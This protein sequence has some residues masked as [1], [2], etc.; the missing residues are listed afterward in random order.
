MM[1]AGRSSTKRPRKSAES[2]LQKS[3]GDAE[4]VA[5]TAATDSQAN[6]PFLAKLEKIG[7]NRK[8]P[9]Q[10]WPAK[11]VRTAKYQQEK[12]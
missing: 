8:N 10:K 5:P 7:K 2:L 6:M 9:Q 3:G 12:P 11:A 4:H 1:P